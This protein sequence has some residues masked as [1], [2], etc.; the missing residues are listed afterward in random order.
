MSLLTNPGQEV[1]EEYF[2][3]Y[4]DRS[5]GKRTVTT[6]LLLLFVDFSH[7]FFFIH[8]LPHHY[9]YPVRPVDFSFLSIII[10]VVKMP[11]KAG[12]KSQ[13]ASLY[14]RFVDAYMKARPEEKRAVSGIS[15]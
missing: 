12:K 11:T 15:F 2:F 14:K 1:D 6:I 7:F 4:R 8:I 9:R 3:S 10:I 5:K 13:G